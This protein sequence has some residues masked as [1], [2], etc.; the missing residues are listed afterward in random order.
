MNII[1]GGGLA[2]LS[3]GARLSGSGQPAIV[4]E[5]GRTVGG[6][7]RT[8]RH[9]DYRFDLGGHRFLTANRQLQSFVSDL[10]GDDLLTVP[11]RSRILLKGNYID[12][13]LSPANAVFGMGLTETGSILLD[14]GREKLRRLIRPRSITSLEDWVVSRF[15]RTMFNLYFRDYSEKVWGIKCRDISKDWVAQRIDGLSLWKFICHSLVRFRSTRVKTLTDSFFYPRQGIGRLADRLAELISERNSI[16]T[17]AEVENIFHAD[18]RITGIRYAKGGASHTLQGNSYVS[19][20]PVTRLVEKMLPAPQE[21]ILSAARQ[22]RFRSLVIAALFVDRPAITDLTWMYFPEKEIP[23]G[24]IH[25]PKNWS[26]ELAPPGSSHVVTE[27]FCNTGDPA[28]NASDECIID[29]AAAHLCRLGFFRR[30]ELIGG[31]VLRIPY[32]YPVFDLDY[33]HHLKVITDYLGNFCNLYLA[34]RNGMFS[35]L[36]MDQAMESGFHAAERV[37]LDSRGCEAAPEK[38]AALPHPFFQP[39]CST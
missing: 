36:N 32:A 6:L 5:R 7:S 27:Y 1:L 34:G 11:R 23:F 12:Y 37:L 13:P 8:I 39:A 2:G 18:G 14:Y 31:K 30:S 28:W 16:L 17:D 33:R 20:I 38:G 22:I 25:E 9:G 24:R 29:S 26:P 4:L 21:N 35:Y 19:S 10:L 3:A 15:G